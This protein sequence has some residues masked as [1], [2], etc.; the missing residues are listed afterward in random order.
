MID[1]FVYNNRYKVKTFKT[2]GKPHGF[3]E[4]EVYLGSCQTFMM[5]HFSKIVNGF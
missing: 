2:L 5:E 1:H 3:D 4:S